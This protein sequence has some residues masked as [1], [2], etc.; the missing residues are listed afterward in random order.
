METQGSRIV[1]LDALRGV[2]ALAIVVHHY[3]H[4][5]PKGARPFEGALWIVYEY[6]RFAVPLFFLLSGYIFFSAYA[7]ALGARRIDGRTFFWLRAS[8]LYPLHIV[9][10]LTVAALQ[11]LA[12]RWT[13]DTFVF[14]NNDLVHFGLNLTFLQFGWVD[15]LMTFNGPTW[16]LSIEAALYLMFFAFA[17]TFGAAPWPRLGFGALCLA[18]GAGRQWLPLWGPVNPYIAEGLSCFF[19]GGCLQLTEGWRDRPKL[20]LA[21]ALLTLGTVLFYLTGGMRETMPTIFAGVTLTV[22]AS[23]GL[24]RLA[25][26]GPLVWLGDISYS[27]YLWHFPIEVALI[28]TSA[29]VVPLPFSSPLMFALYLA[30]VLSVSTLSYRYFEAPARAAIRRWVTPRRVAPAL[31]LG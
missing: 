5:A 29:A 7:A 16:S 18:L 20:A 12:L 10:L 23:P 11:A 2:A 17:R 27:T 13:G 28:V 24:R 1:A 26:R 15:P 8:R 14:H 30:L 3:F 22:L 9:T 19:L 6:G 4:F 31:R 21:L 25:A